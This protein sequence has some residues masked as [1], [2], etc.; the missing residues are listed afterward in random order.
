MSSR[1]PLIARNFWPQSALHMNKIASRSS[2][3][4]ASF[5]AQRAGAFAGAEFRLGHSL[6]RLDA[7]APTF[8]QA[9][10]SRGPDVVFQLMARAIASASIEFVLVKEHN[11][12]RVHM[13]RANCTVP[14]RK[15]R[16]KR[17]IAFD[18]ASAYLL[19]CPFMVALG[20]IACASCLRGGAAG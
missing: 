20:A 12:S 2:L 16:A 3:F 4:L 15:D 17:R 8:A 14:M 11:A 9:L 6:V 10:C 7:S 1:V 5:R 13:R 18:S 19:I